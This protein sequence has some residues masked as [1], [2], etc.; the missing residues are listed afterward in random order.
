[1]L[2]GY[3]NIIRAMEQDIDNLEQK[4][5]NARAHADLAHARNSNTWI[6]FEGRT[7]EINKYLHHANTLLNNATAMAG[8]AN[9]ATKK[10]E[11]EVTSLRSQAI[12]TRPAAVTAHTGSISSGPPPIIPIHAP[13]PVSAYTAPSILTAP[14]GSISTAQ[15]APSTGLAH[16]AKHSAPSKFSGNTE[17]LHFDQWINSLTMYLFTAGMRSDVDKVV[18]A[19][20]F[21]E[22]KAQEQ[23]R[24]YWDNFNTQ[25]VVPTW[26]DFLARM[27]S[28]FRG[29]QPEEAARAKLENICEK[30]DKNFLKFCEEFPVPAIDSIFSDNNLIHRINKAMNPNNSP[31]RQWRRI[32]LHQPE[33][34][35]TTQPQDP[36]AS[37]QDS[38]LQRRRNRKQ[39]RIN[40]SLRE[41]QTYYW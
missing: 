13:V 20:G 18:A 9:Q 7:S 25:N 31:H 39:R 3:K 32:Q 11:A 19:M 14:P 6:E 37:T 1:V 12:G 2:N 8:D 22:G 33:A 34:Y 10:L 4:V 16:S 41:S 40:H 26:K 23:M 30:Y 27:N 5:T 28:L 24:D 36:Q 17:K 21:I 15:T 35:T 38:C 29:L